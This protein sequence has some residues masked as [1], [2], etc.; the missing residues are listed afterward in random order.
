MR[1]TD[2]RNLSFSKRIKLAVISAVTGECLDCCLCVVTVSSLPNNRQEWVELQH[3]R[4][5]SE[6]ATAVTTYLVYTFHNFVYNEN[7]ALHTHTHTVTCFRP[8]SVVII[9]AI[10]EHH[11]LCIQQRSRLGLP[12]VRSSDNRIIAV[13]QFNKCNIIPP[14]GGGHA[15]ALLVEALLYKPEGRRFDSWRCHWN[16]SLTQSFRPHYGPE[17][18]SSSNRNEYQEYFLG[19]NAAGA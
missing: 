9:R 13:I 8:L 7:I 12:R 15:V 5:E 17:V 11:L 19:V 3:R 14:G 18:D 2:L 6:F 1:C 10:T 4:S 16:F